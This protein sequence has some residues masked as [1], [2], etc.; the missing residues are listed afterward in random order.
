MVYQSTGYVATAL[1][2]DPAAITNGG[3][4]SNL[5]GGQRYQAR[6]RSKQGAN[7]SA[8]TAVAEGMVGAPSSTTDGT[9]PANN[10]TGQPNSIVQMGNFGERWGF[11]SARKILT[12]SFP[13][14]GSL[15]DDAG[16]GT[17]GQGETVSG[18]FGALSTSRSD[19]ARWWFFLYQMVCDVEFVEMTEGSSSHADIRLARMNNFGSNYAYIPTHFF[20][21]AL[22]ERG[23]VW[24][25]T[26]IDSYGVTPGTYGYDVVG[27]EMLHAVAGVID[28]PSFTD[29]TKRS[30]E[31]TISS[32]DSY[33]GQGGPGVAGQPHSLMQ[34]DV[35]YLQFALGARTTGIGSVSYSTD[36]STGA[37]TVTGVGG[38]ATWPYT[39][40]STNSV[41]RTIWAPGSADV[42]NYSNYGVGEPSINLAAGGYSYG[43]SSQRGDQSGGHTANGSLYNPNLNSGGV[44]ESSVSP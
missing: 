38:S 21:N 34:Y 5:W 19:L 17:Y 13:S 39:T 31:Y 18:V 30:K 6:V 2:S 43:K 16:A 42:L 8:W 27:H 11:S 9:F 10:Y 28:N 23:D 12:Y 1:W 26:N 14:S 35:D 20:S 29:T 24:F 40:A 37:L 33:V 44:I 32:Y 25:I 22:G 7:T 3:T 15:Y 36:P 4:V 41:Y